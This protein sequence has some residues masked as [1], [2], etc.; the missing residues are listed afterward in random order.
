M[1]VNWIDISDLSFNHILLL[2]Q[3]QLSWFPGWLPEAELAIALRANP[4]VEWYLRHKCP[5]IIPWIDGLISTHSLDSSISPQQI[6]TAEL[7]ILS[8]INDLLVYAIDPSIYDAQ[9]FLGWDS[10]ELLGLADFQDMVVIDVGSG[11]G[12]LAF[13]VADKARAVFAVEPVANLRQYIKHKARAKHINNIFTMDGLITD[14]PFPA[15]SA[16]ITMGGHVF[17]D[18]PAA[19]YTEMRRVTKSGGMIILCPG[20][21]PSETKTHEYLVTQG[22]NWS[23]FQEPTEGLKRKYWKVRD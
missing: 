23:E 22:F 16:D 18:Q 3:A 7:K 21:S 9:P 12:R 17:G 1:P 20:S 8:K 10:N 2:E 6:R 15:E 11:T 5:E 14:L 19:E 13:S 4:V